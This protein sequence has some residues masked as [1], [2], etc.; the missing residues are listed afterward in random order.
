MEIQAR[1]VPYP[2][3]AN[4]SITT[5]LAWKVDG[6]RVGMYANPGSD[7]YSLM[8]D[9]APLDPAYAGTTDLGDGAA[10]TAMTDGVEVAY[11]DGT[12]STVLFHGNGFA[13]ALDIQIAPSDAFKATATGLLGPLAVG[14]EL[15]ALPDGTALPLS[16]VRATQFTQRYQQFAPAW[17]VTDQTSLFDYKAGETTATFD[18]ADFPNQDVAYTVDELEQ[19]QDPAAVQNANDACV[20]ANGQ[21]ED[22]QHCIF[23]IL[24]TKDPNYAQFYALLAQFLANG[25]AALGAGPIVEVTVP[26]PP[27]PSTNLPAGFVQVAADVTTIKGATIGSDGVLYASIQKPDDS[28]A[29]VSVNT[30]SGAPGAT[31]ATTGS[32]GLFLLDGS[33]WLAEDD[34]TGADKCALERL[35]PTTLAEQATMPV[36]C[37]VAGVQAQPVADGVWWLD[38]STADGDGHGGMIWHIDPATNTVDRSVELPFVNG[39]LGSSPTTVIFGSSDE[40][41]GW[42]RLLQGATAFTPMTIPG[43]TFGLYAQGEGVWF[44]SVQGVQPEPQADFYTSSATPDKSIPIDGILTGADEL[45]IYADSSSSDPDQLVRYAIDGTAPSPILSGATLTTANGDHDLGYFDNDPLVIAN[46]MVAKLWLVQD[47]PAEGTT[48]VITQAA[49]TP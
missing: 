22:L 39:F 17:H 35:D 30:T 21:P 16:Q 14:S 44:Q 19:N 15:P 41:S 9:G 42:Y 37:D 45:A 24:A 11:G 40:G 47:W 46:Q 25:P 27:T 5:A 3:L 1:Q 28:T 18:K 36:T 38:R 33:L 2:D 4:V 7:T 12:I 43:P 48:S 34:P 23:D 26:P 31:V 32:G 6:H 13:Q 20:G 8:L 29:V 49:S 10:V